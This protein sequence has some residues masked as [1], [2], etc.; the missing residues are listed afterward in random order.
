MVQLHARA[1]G[2]DEV[3]PTH[4]VA[5]LI[6]ILAAGVS[7]AGITAALTARGFDVVEPGWPESP[8]HRLGRDDDVI[9]VLV[10]DHL[11][12]HAQPQLRR[13]PVMAVDGGAQ[14]LSRTQQVVIE[15]W[16]GTVELTVPDLLG[17]LVLGCTVPTWARA[18]IVL[19]HRI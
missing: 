15:H 16:G 18:L 7:M 1:A 10:A 11:P 19:G 4:E 17:A 14:A 6:D 9:D 12:R 5:A 3:R 2:V 13:H 8:A